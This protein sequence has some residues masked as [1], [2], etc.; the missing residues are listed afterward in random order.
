VIARV[1]VSGPTRAGPCL[2]H[3]Y[4]CRCDEMDWLGEDTFPFGKIQRVSV[5][6]WPGREP[7]LQEILV[8]SEQWI[9]VL[10]WGLDLE[11]IL[12][13]VWFL[14]CRVGIS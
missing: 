9:E 7:M 2:V 8:G 4:Q 5:L 13:C 10:W 12:D 6:V 3:A 11:R 1:C 14:R